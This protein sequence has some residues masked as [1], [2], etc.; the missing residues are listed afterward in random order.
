MYYIIAAHGSYAEGCK[1]GCEMVTGDTS[2][3]IPVAFT[4]DMTKEDVEK[5]YEKILAE[6]GIDGC[7]AIIA[8][9][10][11]G[12]PY[13]A[14]MRITAE[15]KNISLV[16][17]LSQ[18]LLILLNAGETLADAIAQ[19]GELYATPAARKEQKEIQ[20]PKDPTDKNGIV[21]FRL[22][23]RL[24]HGQVA[25]F[26]TRALQAD[27]I[28]IADDEVLK[29]EIGVSALK[30]AVPAGVHLSILTVD[31]AAARLN[32]GIY[33]N[34]RV[35]LIV[36]LKDEIG[37]SALK[38]AV[39]AGVHLSILTVDNAA[40]RL[41][42]GIYSNQRVFLIV[43]KTRTIQRLI[44][45]GLKVKEVNIGNMGEKE[46]R[47]RIKKSVYCTLEEL[48]QIDAV[49]KAGVT[50]YAQMVPNDEKKTFR[51]YLH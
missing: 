29:D 26:W 24:I 19:T 40:A 46:G 14:A 12:T 50:V 11:G 34:Q 31:N 2:S 48:S 38:A 43:N 17:G 13:N 41:N 30:A 28:I 39:P 18:Q 51:S 47:K 45:N 35:F 33:S 25:T 22:D 32:A 27:R 23:E 49:E 10:P 20:P 6:K 1:S 4:E 5:K 37:V 21:N 42:A 7:R 36:V 16:A 8:D 44:E 3:F 15:H 9:L